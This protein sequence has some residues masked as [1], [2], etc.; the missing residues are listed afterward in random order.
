M[1][2]LLLLFTARPEAKV[3]RQKPCDTRGSD[4]RQ[5]KRRGGCVAGARVPGEHMGAK[6]SCSV[7]HSYTAVRGG[8]CQQS[9]TVVHG[10]SGDGRHMALHNLTA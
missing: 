4:R 10:Q 2:I 6:A 5:L 8:R 3:T 7:P 1:M 9:S